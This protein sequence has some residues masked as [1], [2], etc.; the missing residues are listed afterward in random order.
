MKKL[1]VL[2][3]LIS[4]K[5]N[6]QSYLQTTVE[7]T[8][9]KPNSIAVADTSGILVGRITGINIDNNY[10]QISVYYQYLTTDGDIIKQGVYRITS[11][12]ANALYEVVK[13]YIP[14]NLPYCTTQN[15]VYL[16]AFKQLMAQTFGIS[17]SFIQIH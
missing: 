17:D 10:N 3:L 2:F 7:I 11:V 12:Q 9:Q 15:Y 16:I 6:S 8:Y 13:S 1:I 5:V 4:L 14:S